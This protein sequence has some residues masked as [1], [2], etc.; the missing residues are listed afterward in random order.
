MQKT[1]SNINRR[2]FL[3]LTGITSA[4]FIMGLSAKGNNGVPEVANLTNSG[5]NS[6]A[7]ATEAFELTP[8]VVIEKSGAITIFNTKPEMGQGVFGAI[9][10]LIAEELEVSMD[11]ITIK[12]T[13]GEKKFGG[14]QSAGGSSSIRS[15]Y[16]NLRKVGA[17]AREMLVKAASQQWG[18]TVE[19]CYA[20]NAK[21]FHKPSGKS[22][23]YGD[24]VEAASK[25]EVPQSPKLK[26]P[27]D[28]KILEK[29]MPRPDTPLK[30][31]GK[32]TF[33]IDVSVP[34]M[35]YASVE[36]TPVLGSK[37]VSFDAAAARKVKGVLHVETSTR[38]IGIYSYE[39]VAVIAENYW[40]ALQG[41]K[42]LKVQ[43]DH[44]GHDT[45][46]SKTYEQSLRD[47]A[48]TEGVVDHTQGDFDKAVAEAPV[49]VEAFYETPIVSHSPMEPMNCVASWQQGDKLEIWTSTQV[50]GSIKK[51]FPKTYGIP[52]ENLTVHTMFNGGG[53]GR[54][55]Y[56]DFIH[57]AV[58]LSKK[59]GKPVKVIWTRED[60]TQQGPFRPMTFSAM[61]GALSAD[62]KAVAFQHK[63][64]SPSIDAS[65]R[66][67]YDKT[68]SDRGMTEGISEQKYEIPN[69]K[70]NYVYAD[71]HIPIAAWRS[72]TSST[73]AFAHE[74]FI[75]EMAVNAKKDPMAFRLELLTKDSDTKNVLLKLKEVSNWDKP[76]PKG[77]GRGV[78]QYEFFAGLGGYVIEV[79]KKGTGIKI[80]KIYAVIDLGTVV[81]P[82]TVRAQVEG[83][84]VMALTAAIKNGITFEKGQ[85]VQSNFHNN[86]LVRINEMPPVEVHILANGGPKIKGV[87][88]PG[89][90]PF[91]PAL[92]NAIFAATGKRIRRLPFDINK[93]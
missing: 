6:L 72:V 45:F 43:W 60:D 1:S 21:V 75:D 22:L 74:C 8:F 24:L 18:A 62:G 55:L 5:L 89:L 17:S 54:R 87:G 44:Q 57:D 91:A 77:W 51:D 52:E 58:Q 81:N 35:V 11:Q 32:A 46:N 63:V 66:M 84:A 42:A 92:C 71:L 12:Q 73:L 48:K 61:K 90:P 4:G 2:N 67:N 82:D 9:P 29:P 20:E 30:V 37:L 53:F 10:S 34:G 65:G 14:G 25:L 76:L 78:A 70:N 38:T 31:S 93:V 47:L 59:V 83:A 85:A 16:N 7:D 19:E 40:A 80:E 3:R 49:K 68:K 88:E 50:P 64:I 23:S 13:G 28:F 33:G 39:G 69:M 86:P 15:N 26:D 27:K 79:S 36:R 41:R 56:T